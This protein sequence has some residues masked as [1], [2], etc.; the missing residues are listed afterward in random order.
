MCPFADLKKT[1][2]PKNTIIYY[3]GQ[4]LFIYKKWCIAI[5]I[6]FDWMKIICDVLDWIRRSLS[7]NPGQSL[8][9]NVS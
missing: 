6:A 5:L 2:A 1:L 9:K 7:R 4:A 3:N 8:C